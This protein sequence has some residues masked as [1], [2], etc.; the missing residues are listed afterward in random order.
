MFGV[1]TQLAETISDDAR[2]WRDSVLEVPTLNDYR[3]KESSRRLT[4]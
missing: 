3:A 1:T 2:S 4:G